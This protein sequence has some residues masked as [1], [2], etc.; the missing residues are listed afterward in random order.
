MEKNN[1]I[2]TSFDMLTKFLNEMPL[3]DALKYG[4]LGT[5]AIPALYYGIEK[6]NELCNKAIENGYN[7]TLLKN[8]GFTLLELSK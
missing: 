5:I 4:A 8:G 1:I 7:V 6:V 2:I 3:E